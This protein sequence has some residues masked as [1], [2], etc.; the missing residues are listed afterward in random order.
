MRRALPLF[1]AL[2][3][4]AGVTG[5]TRLRLEAGGTARVPAGLLYLPKGPFLRAMA[6]GHEETLADFLYIWAIQYYG[7]YDE[8]AR[9]K[10]LD[11]VFRGAI[12][13]LD[14]RFT[15]VYLV[16]ALIMTLEAGRRDLAMNL[17][18]K[19]LEKMPDNWE[20]AY[21]AG[22]ECYNAGD[23]RKARSY[24]SRA[25]AMPGAPHQLTRLA[26]KMLERAGDQEAALA[27]YRRILEATREEHTRKVI[28][29]WIDR[30]LTERGLSELRQAVARFREARGHCPP[31]QDSLLRAGFL[32]ELPRT[33][34]G[35]P[36]YYDPQECLVLPA[37]G[38]TVGVGP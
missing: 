23:F 3:L 34:S 35:A 20:I 9:Y 14:P 29:G 21:W 5:V 2:V 37:P 30:A 28:K 25:A 18:D 8:K 32:K 22:W 19:G 4:L 11:Q 24:W 36:F 33:P 6:L 31:D 15:E 38:Q 7:T 16:G 26:A 13:E 17:Y 12:T 1:L 10:Y 27:E